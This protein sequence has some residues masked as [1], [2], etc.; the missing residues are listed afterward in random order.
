M[1][2]FLLIRKTC[3]TWARKENRKFPSKQEW[4][5]TI[6]HKHTHHIC[7]L[8][9]TSA[10]WIILMFLLLF[11]CEIRK[12]NEIASKRKS[13]QQ[14]LSFLFCQPQACSFTLKF[15]RLREQQITTIEVKYFVTFLKTEW[16]TYL[17]MFP[18]L[19]KKMQLN[20]SLS[21]NILCRG[22]LRNRLLWVQ[23]FIGAKEV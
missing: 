19:Y 15:L 9:Y 21:D 16:F 3:H 14:Q 2:E 20:I 5:Q 18:S 22:V 12:T 8:F 11:P 7:T 17:C 4:R 13:I 23:A 6:N 10:I 1:T